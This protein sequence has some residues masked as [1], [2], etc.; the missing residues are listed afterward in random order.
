M[1]EVFPYIAEDAIGNTLKHIR[2]EVY[3]HWRPKDLMR[4]I[5]WRFYQFLKLH[6][7]TLPQGEVRDWDDH[8]EVEGKMWT[9]FFGDFLTNGRSVRERT[10]P[11]VLRH[12]QLR[13]RQLIVLCNEIARRAMN[14]GCFPFVR[15]NHIR[16]GVKHGERQL[17]REVLNS[18]SAVYP[19]IG[20]IIEALSGAP[21]LFR[22]SELDRRAPQ[23]A[24]AWA[25]MDYSPLR[26]AQLV[27]EI[28]VV[29]RVRSKNLKAGY[30][31][32]DFEY[33][34]EDRLTLATDCEC[35]IHPMF[36]F[37]LSTVVVPSVRVYPFPDRPDFDALDHR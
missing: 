36:F 19:N 26:F 4:L 11:Y 18:Y 35:V 17:A 1:A 25:P 21:L 9:P 12:T 34:M 15:E 22:G 31:E 27:A 7:I 28:G 13:P 20:M 16:E 14:D 33:T 24:S 10:F 29:G 23:T 3:L 32:A 30:I 37:K 2:D 6:N 5:S 8:R